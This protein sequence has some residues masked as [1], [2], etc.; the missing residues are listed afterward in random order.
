MKT[1]KNY[2]WIITIADAIE[3][4]FFAKN[5]WQEKNKSK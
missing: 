5:L 2:T 1:K 3:K 4:S